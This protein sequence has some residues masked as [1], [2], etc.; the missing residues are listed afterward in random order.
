MA[1]YGT[2]VGTQ[3]HSDRDRPT[4]RPSD[5]ARVRAAIAAVMG[6]G[7]STQRPARQANQGLRNFGGQQRRGAID[8]A[9]DRMQSGR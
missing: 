8:D 7:S 3:A 2:P 9:V 6:Q 4:A 5:P 1:D